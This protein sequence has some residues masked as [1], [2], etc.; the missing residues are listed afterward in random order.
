M[1]R[2]VAILGVT[3]IMATIVVAGAFPAFAEPPAEP[4]NPSNLGFCSSFLG[5]LQL[6]DDVNKLIKAGVGGYDNPGQLYKDRARDP[7]DREC[8]R[9]PQ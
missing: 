8:L 3:A 1:R 4:P 7:L 9:R 5:P 2:V 6:R